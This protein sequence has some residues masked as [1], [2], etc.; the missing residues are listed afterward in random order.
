MT[1]RSI[2][3]VRAG[4]LRVTSQQCGDAAAAAVSADGPEEARARVASLLS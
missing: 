1:P 2:P 3:V 4:L